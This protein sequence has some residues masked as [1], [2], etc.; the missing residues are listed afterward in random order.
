M[1]RPFGQVS[2]GRRT[3]GSPISVAEYNEWYLEKAPALSDEGAAADEMGVRAFIYRQRRHDPKTGLLKDRGLSSALRR[4]RRRGPHAVLVG[5]VTGWKEIADSLG[6]AGG[7]EALS[8]GLRAVAATVPGDAQ[9]GRVGWLTFA[10][11]VP[12][13]EERAR[14]VATQICRVVSETVALAEHPDKRVGVVIGV[15]PNPSLRGDAYA[16]AYRCLGVATARGLPIVV[17][18]E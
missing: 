5:E 10:V 14:E 12:G 9:V 13:R 17:R 2:C 3:T 16:Y 6:H 1:T 4:A 18:P 15:D 7:E 11:L 8:A